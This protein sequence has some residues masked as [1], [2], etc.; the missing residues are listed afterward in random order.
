MTG[1]GAVGLEEGDGTR[2]GRLQEVGE[3]IHNQ[4]LRKQSFVSIAKSSPVIKREQ[5]IAHLAV[6]LMIPNDFLLLNSESMMFTES[7]GNIME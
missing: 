5:L 4:Q 2:Q 7:R 1:N 3:L 6:I